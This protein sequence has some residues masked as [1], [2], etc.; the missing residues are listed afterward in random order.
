MRSFNKE[1]AFSFLLI[2]SICL[3][4]ILSFNNDYTNKLDY[5]TT[6]FTTPLNPSLELNLINHSKISI[7]S[8]QEL[9]L[10]GK[11]ESWLGDG[12]KTN[13]IQI[14]G[15]NISNST[16][17]LIDLRNVDI[18]VEISGNSLNGGFDAI[19]LSNTSH[20]SI[21]DNQITNP[22][23]A[24]IFL[25][26]SNNCSI[27]TNRIANTGFTGIWLEGSKYS[28]IADNNIV[29]TGSD[30]ISLHSYSSY[31]KISLNNV[32]YAGHYGIYVADSANSQL[33]ENFVHRSAYAGLE[34][35]YSAN[36][37]IRSN[38]IFKNVQ[39]H[40]IA[41]SNSPNTIVSHNTIF[42]A[43]TELFTPLGITVRNSP[44]SQVYENSVQG[45]Y[46][47][48]YL[49][50]SDN[51]TVYENALDNSSI[52][53]AIHHASGRINIYSNMISNSRLGGIEFYEL[54]NA[55]FYH[56][57]IVNSTYYQL[58]L[59]ASSNNTIKHNDFINTNNYYSSQGYDN[60]NTGLKN[61]I[62]F[63]H[64]NDL[65]NPDTNT[66][67]IVD[68]SYSLDGNSNNADDFPLTDI[69]HYITS[70]IIL[71]PNGGELLNETVIIRWTPSSESL[72][73]EVYYSLQYS[74]DSGSTW[75]LL[76]PNHEQ[77]SYSWETSEVVDG[78]EYLLKVIA[79]SSSI[80]NLQKFDISDAVFS[81]NNTAFPT[82][83]GERTSET[84]NAFPLFEIITF[85]LLS[86]GVRFLKKK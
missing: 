63:N 49:N 71:F 56:N 38:I 26:E 15:F 21:I 28:E 68:V 83:T 18:F 5:S 69:V 45:D 13:P 77:N 42:G 85:L 82:S 24:G 6:S 31:S 72:G 25:S 36:S 30:G 12:N 33:V 55:Y 64:W 80:K 86:W 84:T 35:S 23:H 78:S 39:A 16:G 8:N 59:D 32:S 61:N 20:I 14:S 41:A 22:S 73:Y 43:I 7:R 52:G 67:G 51:S 37:L 34:I 48:I 57:T 79:Y 66:D 62:S 54:E 17:N 81:V 3:L 40:S 11:T 19:Y 47:G 65:T 74:P 10:L 70:P 46:Y 76:T 75:F 58:Y 27:I 4:L 1:F 53:I 2:T 50:F 60:G 44:N 29:T 9:I